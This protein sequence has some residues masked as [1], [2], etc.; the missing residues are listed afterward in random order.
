MGEGQP[1]AE[2]ITSAP[3]RSFVL[4]QGRMTPAQT[5]AVDTLFGR[6]GIPYSGTALDASAAFGRAA[7]LVFEIGSGMGETTFEIARLHPDTNYLA[8]EVHLPGVGALLKRVEDQIHICQV[9]KT[10]FQIKD[11]CRLRNFPQCFLRQNQYSQGQ[12]S[13]NQYSQIRCRNP[14]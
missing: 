13:Q 8:A 3:I 9:L 10:T 7:P 5:R 2:R 4:R 1:G 11:Q 12:Y 14:Q 6:Y